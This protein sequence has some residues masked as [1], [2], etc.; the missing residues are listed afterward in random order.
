MKI[1]KLI[2]AL[3]W[4]L[5]LL[6]TVGCSGGQDDGVGSEGEN[7]GEGTQPPAAEDVIYSEEELPTVVATDRDL[8]SEA[9]TALLSALKEALGADAYTSGGSG[10]GE[11][12]EIVIGA[13]NRNVTEKAEYYLRR[14]RP[15]RDEETVAWLI[16]SDGTSI[17]IVYES[18]TDYI[19]LRGAIDHFTSE[20]VSGA[21]KLIAK[22]GVLTSGEVSVKDYYDAYDKVYLSEKWD[23]L[24]GAL[25]P[26]YAGELVES[27]QNLYSLYTDDLISWFANLYDPA[28]GGYYY[29]NSGRNTYG[30]LPDIESTEQ[31]LRFIATSGI[32]AEY[33]GGYEDVLPLQMKEKIVYFLKSLQDENGYFYHPQWSRELS[34]SKLSRLSRDLGNAVSVLKKLGSAPTYNTPN[35]DKGDGITADEYIAGRALTGSLRSGRTALASRVSLA[36]SVA[37]PSH[38]VD[39]ASFESYL[40]SLDIKN[41]SYSVG[42]TLTA[43]KSAIIY[44]DKVLKAEGADYSLMDI[45]IKWL[46]DNQNP[47]TGL[48]HGTVN[49]YAINGLMKISGVYGSAEVLLPNA[50]KAVV[51][52]VDAITSDEK[53]GAVVDIYNTWYAVSRVLRHMR[54]YGNDS[55]K[56]KA[57]EVLSDLRANAA[58]ALQATA[59]KIAVFKKEDGSFS[60]TPN[61]SSA[62]S[63]G[64]PVAV[65]GTNEG[66]VNATVICTSDILT[67]IYSALDLS[68]YRV[69][70]YTSYDMRRY[71]SILSDLDPVIKDVEEA[72]DTP[73]DFEANKA[74]DTP[75]GVTVNARSAANGGYIKVASGYGTNKTNVVALKTVNGTSDS[76]IINCANYS[77]MP[78]YVFEGD[79]AVKSASSSYYAQITMGN[80][81][82]FTLR[83]AEGKVSIVESSSPSAKKSHDNVLSATP[84]LG[85]WFHIRAE[86]YTLKNGEARIKFFYNGELIAV[87]DNFYSEDGSKLAEGA[88]VPAPTE[89]KQVQIWMMK[90]VDAEIY[91]DNL[92]SYKTYD[93][94]EPVTGE[95]SPELNVDK[96]AK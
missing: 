83:L 24:K 10:E 80:C 73:N 46:S 75:S 5:V 37:V 64:C 20:Y 1:K 44:R 6:F 25:D 86:Y 72:K 3:C 11:K 42:N 26:E 55:D 43:Q 88:K 21:D 49:Y 57:A 32:A 68:D 71:L 54:T 93:V 30:F 85:E 58:V 59:E 35:G 67:Y 94:Y 51:A 47:E 45:L 4:L 41:S 65:P 63:Q 61:A 14:M 53:C 39:K 33:G 16:Y 12:H 70:M 95:D 40:A 31:A 92:A 66:D 89:Y 15:E 48:W 34:D 23:A 8:P 87:T 76:V 52:A 22:R 81:Y 79:F 7:G 90:S 18:D 19:G 62:N 96:D 82:M 77:N 28:V 56:Q 13:S 17:A 78:C 74:E 69:P 29:S 50:D 27:M 36:A 84:E 2:I 91:F 9:T 60:Y 38:L